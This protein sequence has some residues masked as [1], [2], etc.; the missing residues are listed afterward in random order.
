MKLARI[1]QRN[2]LTE[3]LKG[4]PLNEERCLLSR[5]WDTKTIRKSD[6]S[7]KAEQF[8]QKFCSWHDFCL[9]L[10]FFAF[11]CLFFVLISFCFLLFS[12]KCA[13]HRASASIRSPFI[14]IHAFSRIVKGQE[15]F[16]TK[17]H[18]DSKH[19][20]M[21]SIVRKMLWIRFTIAP[22]FAEK[23]DDISRY[24]PL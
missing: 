13:N 23:I 12:L 7:L 8:F 20:S 19:V 24:T 11:F 4:L 9:F 17:T 10:P 1:I 6:L 21:R 5:Y 22:F 2:S 16:F 18:Q 14:I 3:T 15:S